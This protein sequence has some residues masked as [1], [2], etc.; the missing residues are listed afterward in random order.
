MPLKGYLVAFLKWGTS[1]PLPHFEERVNER[2]ERCD[3]ASEGHSP[4]LFRH[5]RSLSHNGNPRTI[6]SPEQMSR[7]TCE[8]FGDGL[9]Q[10]RSRLM[11][12]CERCARAVEAPTWCRALFVPAMWLAHHCGTRSL[13]SN[14]LEAALGSPNIQQQVALW[15]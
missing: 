12:G 13:T 15:P 10:E 4:S 1:L 11:S 8:V 9:P 14:S 2:L 7:E 6:Q 5:P 3:A